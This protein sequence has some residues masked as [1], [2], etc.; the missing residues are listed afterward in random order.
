MAMDLVDWF[1]ERLAL[2]LPGWKVQARYQPELSFGRHFVP[3]PPAARR[4]AVLV[5]LQPQADSWTVPLTLR[6]AE[7]L[8]H[9]GQMSLPGGL[10]EPNERSEDAARR[11][12]LEELGA[13]PA[14]L[15]LLGR[16][17][18]IYLFNSNFAVEP[19]LAAT[20]SRTPWAPNVAEVAELIEAP[21]DELC[22]PDN[23]IVWQREFNGVTAR[24]PGI[25]CARHRIWGATC[26]I[27]AELIA[28]VEEY[29]KHRL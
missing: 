11:E 17:S 29:R 19:W 10:I 24:V 13:I 21:L 25:V 2:P 18:P 7:L 22:H 6:P 14:D 26:M 27:L 5:L 20:R 28:L 8:D 4:A 23:S 12:L 1:T 3:P 16:L 9:A 15:V